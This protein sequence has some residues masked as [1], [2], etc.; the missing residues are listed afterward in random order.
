MGLNS[1]APCMSVTVCLL[2]RMS[3]SAKMVGTARGPGGPDRTGPPAIGEAA[4]RSRT[5]FRGVASREEEARLDAVVLHEMLEEFVS[6]RFPALFVGVEVVRFVNDNEVPRLGGEQ[7]VV[8]AVAVGAQ[9]VQGGDHLRMGVKEVRARGV[10]FGEISVQP[11]VEHFP[12]AF[13]PLLDE[14][15]GAEHQQPFHDAL[16]QQRPE[17]EASLNRFAQAHI[18]GNQPADRPAA[19]DAVADP[20]LVRQEGDA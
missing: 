5:V 8:P 9:G 18:V 16:R 14:F 19:Q 12:Q 11:D 7:P 6:E 17:D 3:T 1:F 4:T 13:L 15:R 2:L 10:Q 20:E